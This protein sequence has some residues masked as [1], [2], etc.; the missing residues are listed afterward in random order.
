MGN[1]KLDKNNKISNNKA[2]QKIVKRI[3]KMYAIWNRNT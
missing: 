1:K 3:K 2:D